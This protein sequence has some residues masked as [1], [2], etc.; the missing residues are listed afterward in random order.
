MPLPYPC[1]RQ[2]PAVHMVR[3]LPHCCCDFLD[4]PGF[5]AAAMAHVLACLVV[6]LA[7]VMVSYHSLMPCLTATQKRALTVL[8]PLGLAGRR[9]GQ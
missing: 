4:Q 7:S 9:V 3:S 1:L 8:T 2:I 5:D 6:D